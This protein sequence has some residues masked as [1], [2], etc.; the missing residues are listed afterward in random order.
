MKKSLILL[1]S[2]CLIGLAFSSYSESDKCDAKSKTTKTSCNEV[3][4][5]LD[6]KNKKCCWL[7]Q[8]DVKEG[9]CVQINPSKYKEFW[10]WWENE[11]NTKVTSLDCLSKYL[12]I[13]MFL[14]FAFIIIL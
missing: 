3:S 12:D 14:I 1:L 10:T 5:Q 4:K 13:K 8:Q 2:A 11:H 7:E 6:D 9:S